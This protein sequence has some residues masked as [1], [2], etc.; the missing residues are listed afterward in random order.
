[1]AKM[2][3]R[4]LG[5]YILYYVYKN[6]QTKERTQTTIDKNKNSMDACRASGDEDMEDIAN[7]VNVNAK[8]LKCRY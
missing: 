3:T 4:I 6:V 2:V 1:M 8:P 7:V 5:K